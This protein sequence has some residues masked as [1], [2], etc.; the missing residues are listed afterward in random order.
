MFSFFKSSKKSPVATPTEP[1]KVEETTQK[2]GDDFV[3]I[4][5]G[6]PAPLYPNVSP[7]RPPPPVPT[8]HPA[9]TR[10]VN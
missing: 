4:G 3:L 6:T 7:M 2:N 1:P 9:M 8:P 10:Q 5:G